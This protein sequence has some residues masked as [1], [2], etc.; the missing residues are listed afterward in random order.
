MSA[1]LMKMNLPSGNMRGRT[2]AKLYRIEIK[3]VTVHA[4]GCLSG[5]A[6]TVCRFAHSSA[7]EAIGCLKNSF[8][9]SG[10]SERAPLHRDCARDAFPV[11]RCGETLI[12][13]CFERAR[14][15]SRAVQFQ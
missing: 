3:T 6:A 11:S 1:P 12:L 14:L 13:S 10:F 7:V 4:G 5:S 9:K 15:F 8:G 2:E